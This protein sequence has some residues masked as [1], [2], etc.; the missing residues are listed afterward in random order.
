MYLW[1]S[2]HRYISYF[3]LLRE[4]RSS[5]TTVALSTP[6]IQILVSKTQF[7]KKRTWDPL[8]KW[9]I[10]GQGQENCRM[11][12]KYFVVSENKEVLR[13]GCGYVKRTQLEEGPNGQ[14]WNDLRNEMNNGSLRL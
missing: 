4:P 13:K 1:V 11:S 7:S 9:L 10:P 12:L 5:D 3:Y 14:R 2:I 6:S 8:E